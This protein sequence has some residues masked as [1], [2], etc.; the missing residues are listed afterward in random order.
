MLDV[1][2]F[3]CSYLCVYSMGVISVIQSTLA[4]KDISHSVSAFNPTDI[5]ANES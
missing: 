3:L 5:Y 1:I 2:H 4:H